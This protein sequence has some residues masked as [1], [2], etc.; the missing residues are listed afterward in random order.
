LPERLFK[1]LP[2]GPAKGRCV[3]ANALPVMISQYYELLGWDSETGNP[4]EGR[5]KELGLEWTIEKI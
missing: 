4:T 1:A 3:D 2:D 5:L